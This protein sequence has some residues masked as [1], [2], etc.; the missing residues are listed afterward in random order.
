MEHKNLTILR[1][2]F[3]LS[4]KELSRR[5]GIPESSL[6]MT[7]RGERRLTPERQRCILAALGIDPVTAAEIVSHLEEIRKSMPK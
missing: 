1:E 2:A 3:G 6:A 4:R 7:E 5:T